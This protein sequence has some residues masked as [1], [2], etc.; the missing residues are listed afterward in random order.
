MAL[1]A[2]EIKYSR[3]QVYEWLLEY[4]N[5]NRVKKLR[6][7]MLRKLGDDAQLMIRRP[8]GVPQPLID[9]LLSDVQSYVIDLRH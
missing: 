2:W 5:Q 7:W 9:L 6:T 4:Y 3:D 8:D 1:G